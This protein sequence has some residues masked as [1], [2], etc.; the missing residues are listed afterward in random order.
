MLSDSGAVPSMV[1]RKRK[2]RRTSLDSG[3]I[4]G[5]KESH[6]QEA[7]VLPKSAMFAAG[8]VLISRTVQ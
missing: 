6:V 3:E 8:R 7:F 1:K 2:M 4:Y 5:G